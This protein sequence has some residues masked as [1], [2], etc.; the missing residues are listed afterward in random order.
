MKV[1][2]KNYVW[3]QDARFVTNRAFVF[4][5]AAYGI[6]RNIGRARQSTDVICMRQT[7]KLRY[8]FVTDNQDKNTYSRNIQELFFFFILDY[9]YVVVRKH[10]R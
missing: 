1:S 9:K 5:R 4:N 7:L 8:I 6:I 3:N 2:D 10:M